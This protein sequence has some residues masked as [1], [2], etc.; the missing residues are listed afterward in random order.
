[1][2]GEGTELAGYRIER[3]L[4]TGGMATVYE[5]T[6][7]SLDRRVAL[8]VMGEAFTG[9]AE[10]RARFKREAL[11][12]AG[13]DHDHVVAVHEA[14][15]AG[16]LLYIAMRLIRGPN[17]KEL[18]RAGALDDDRVLEL[19]TPVADALDTAH[20]AGLVHRDIKPQNILVGPRDHAYL[21]DFGLTKAPDQTA[22]TA[23]GRFMGTPNYTSPEQV[24]GE[25]AT[26]A[27]DIYSFA[28]VVYECLTGC[29][30]YP[31]PTEAA[32]L[33]AHVSE[34]PPCPSEVRPELP[35][36]VD[37]ALSRGMAKQPADRQPTATAF[38]QDL[39][40][41]LAGAGRGEAQTVDAEVA[42]PTPPPS[43]GVTE[44]LAGA[45]RRPR[46]GTIAA[47]AAVPAA[48]VAAILL[49]RRR[50]RRRRR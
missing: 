37:N 46:A 29:V 31:R 44:R 8:K 7:L 14:G 4:G 45:R 10:F 3:V 30:P 35:S 25:P 34:P 27:S 40:A 36:A 49:L 23:S 39:Q 11:L 33:F 24:H 48:A 5:A 47:L 19:L 18:I 1:M 20:E 16:A 41:G 43:T 38:M 28:A 50:R 21:A 6:Q 26:P 13:L 12:Q 9:D 22:L 42:S 15:E 2:L 17:L 32:L